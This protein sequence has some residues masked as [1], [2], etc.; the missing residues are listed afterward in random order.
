LT[1]RLEK[2]QSKLL[3]GATT[4]QVRQLHARAQTGVSMASGQHLIKMMQYVIGHPVIC[5]CH[6]CQAA[7]QYHREAASNRRSAQALKAAMRARLDADHAAAAAEVSDLQVL[8]KRCE[9]CFPP[10]GVCVH[11]AL[12]SA[13]SIVQ[14]AKAGVALTVQMQASRATA[15]LQRVWQ[16]HEAARA[17]VRELREAWGAERQDLQQRVHCT[18][19]K[20]VCTVLES[21]IRASMCSR[22]ICSIG[23]C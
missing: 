19:P 23:V 21:P 18:G 15:E 22:V 6:R 14:C 5:I 2:L 11:T 4:L 9:R 17:E 8:L 12:R 13:S 10:C 1:A 3:V 7:R 20:D 16:K